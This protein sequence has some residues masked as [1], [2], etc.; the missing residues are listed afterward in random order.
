MLNA[1]LKLFLC[2]LAVTFISSL[3]TKSAEQQMLEREE[4]VVIEKKDAKM[5][6]PK[7]IF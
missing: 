7:N 3:A 6:T 5:T 4:I 2:L 1:I